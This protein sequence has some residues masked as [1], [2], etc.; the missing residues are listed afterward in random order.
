M[1]L[2]VYLKKD[3]LLNTNVYAIVFYWIDHLIKN[4]L[5]L[6]RYGYVCQI[7]VGNKTCAIKPFQLL[8]SL[9][10]AWLSPFGGWDSLSHILVNLHIYTYLF[11]FNNR[12]G[13]EYN[14][15]GKVSRA[16][17]FFHIT[18]YFSIIYTFISGLNLKNNKLKCLPDGIYHRA[19][20]CVYLKI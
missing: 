16:R 17:Y 18:I 20:S 12:T 11:I 15:M 10:F 7:L 14:R 19:H 13:L 4:I 9:G 5:Y 3:L 2:R 6:E 8:I 1:L